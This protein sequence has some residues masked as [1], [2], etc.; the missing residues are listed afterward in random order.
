MLPHTL[1]SLLTEYQDFIKYW[2]N[3][4]FRHEKIRHRDETKRFYTNL[5]EVAGTGIKY[6]LLLLLPQPVYYPGQYD[7][8]F[9]AFGFEFWI[10]K[11]LGT[12]DIRNMQNLIN[13]SKAIADQ[14]IAR[15]KEDSRLE[16]GKSTPFTWFEIQNLVG[17]P[18]DDPLFGDKAVGW[19]FKV[20]MGNQK[21]FTYDSAIWQ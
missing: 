18:I 5:D 14:F 15:L 13:E 21:A 11:N 20:S 9:E 8:K 2:E 7:S 6:P 1:P 4:A 3:L 16:G 10:L 19:S 12:G 17:E